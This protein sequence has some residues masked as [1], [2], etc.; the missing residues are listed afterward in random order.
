[1]LRSPRR[2]ANYTTL[3]SPD[4]SQSTI[5]SHMATLAA[6]LHNIDPFAIK[7][8]DG[9]ILDGIRW[10]G[11]AYLSTFAIGFLLVRKIA[12]TGR[13]TLAP[14]ETMDFV[15]TVAIGVILGGRLGYV[16][17]YKPQLLIEFF[18]N[19]PYWG[20][21]Q[22]NKGGM[23]SHGGMIG[24]G[25]AVWW[26]AWRSKRKIA[27]AA[28]L[29]PTPP[30]NAPKPAPH[31]WLH[32]FDFASFTATVGFFF[33]RLANFINAELLG[34]PCDPNFAWAV[35]FPQELH[36]LSTKWLGSGNPDDMLALTGAAE[37]VG[38]A[39][40]QWTQAIASN[41][42]NFVDHT[43][44]KIIAAIQEGGQSGSLIGDLVAPLLT[45]HH[46]SQLYAAFTEGVVVFVVLF[47]LWLKPRKP[48]II[49]ATFGALYGLMRI[50]NEF[51]RTPDS[52]IA[53]QEFA[54]LHLTRGQLL[55][56]VLTLGSLA[57]LY[58]CAKRNVP[59]MG[60]LLR[61]K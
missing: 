18:G 39:A 61:E 42:I 31:R 7:F 12:K 24:V 58:W 8:P 30:A 9:F 43:I 38:V 49:T 16:F 21:F 41:D 60:G 23:S 27:A 29:T 28:T 3:R 52:H 6:W 37:N 1:M 44:A 54:A 5:L 10:Y 57:L 14:V 53:N 20:V 15:I 4:P 45:A 26:Y 19:F 36:D 32:L 17:F 56:F 34:R 51:Y 35:K 48:G 50:L 55:S 13:T 11:L 25:V 59:K 33:G 46:P 22:L 47:I 40:A 2:T